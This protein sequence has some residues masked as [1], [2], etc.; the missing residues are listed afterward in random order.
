MLDTKAAN[1]LT[2]AEAAFWAY[3]RQ[4]FPAPM[5]TL[6]IVGTRCR[7]FAGHWPTSLDLNCFVPMLFGFSRCWLQTQ[8]RNRL[9]TGRSA[10]KRLTDLPAMPQRVYD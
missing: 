7:R 2:N 6:G 9:I 1:A 10:L 3:N 5:F 4:C 8:S